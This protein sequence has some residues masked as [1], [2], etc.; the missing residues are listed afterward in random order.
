MSAKIGIIGKGNVGNALRQGLERATHEV[1]IVGNEPIAGRDIAAWSDVVI[2]AIP[3]SAINEIIRELGESLHNKVVVDVTNA[4]TTDYQLAIGFSTSGAEELQR[5]I[6]TARVVKAFNTIFAEHMASG[7]VKGEKLSL[8]AAGDDAGAKEQVLSLGRDMGFDAVD[9][10]PLQ[11]AR[12]LE[13]LGYIF[14][15]P[16]R[17]HIEYGD[18]DWIQAYPLNVNFAGI[19]QLKIKGQ[20]FPSF[21]GRPNKRPCMEG[22]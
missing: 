9:A 21:I 12:Q 3:Y 13:A 14:Q 8:F 2:L 19:Q 6:P 5:K 16:T 18:S 11:N 15:Y 1:R 22:T 10:G 17:L 4:L 20:L 7:Q